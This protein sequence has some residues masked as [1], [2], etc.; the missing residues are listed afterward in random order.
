[1]GDNKLGTDVQEAVK[2]FVD[3][4]RRNVLANS[5]SDLADKLIDILATSSSENTVTLDVTKFKLVAD[6]VTD[7][8]PAFQ[9][10]VFDAFTKMKGS[11]SPKYKIH[12][13]FPSGKYKFNTAIDFYGVKNIG[14]IGEGNTTANPNKAS[15]RSSYLDFS[16]TPDHKAFI[17]LQ[18]N[19]T[20]RGLWIEASAG[21]DF[22]T[23]AIEFPYFCQGAE[24]SY[25]TVTNAEIG[26]KFG[27]WNAFNVRL[28]NVSTGT[29]ATAGIYF[30]S[31]GGVFMN[32]CS[33]S[34][35]KEGFVFDSPRWVTLIGCGASWG[36]RGIVFKSALGGNAVTLIGCDFGGNIAYSFQGPSAIDGIT[37]IG[38]QSSASAKDI[39]ESGPATNR[40]VM[41]NSDN[42]GW[43]WGFMDNIQKF[44]II[45]P[46]AANPTALRFIEQI[47]M[48]GDFNGK[49]MVFNR[50]D[51]GATNYSVL[52]TDFIVTVDNSAAPR[53][54]TLPSALAVA[55]RSF[56]IKDERGN[57]GAQA[58]TVV[59]QGGETIDGNPN[60][61]L[62]VNYDII[63]VYSNGA[64]WFKI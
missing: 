35:S 27:P 39:E 38:A 18:S 63:T 16:G 48:S 11:G 20:L 5:S 6:G 62:S 45:G 28:N 57:A 37:M 8:S 43:G 14:V 2:G 21:G 7:N 42:Y 33:D 50:K 22:G 24:I 4:L 60:V 46:S 32:Q 41:I 55:G 26:I 13:Y 34:Q 56:I 54:I 58:I 59:G 49:G 51:A 61:V 19:V 15:N 47:Y 31:V 10:M 36:Q 12:F 44:S 3:K 25:V 9:Q 53:Q 1:M 29:C 64:N 23:P 30:D 52:A 17:R 40:Y